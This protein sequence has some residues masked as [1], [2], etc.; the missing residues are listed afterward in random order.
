M[1]GN[2][3]LGLTRDVDKGF[4]V[5]QTERGPIAPFPLAGVFEKDPCFGPTRFS[6]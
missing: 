2:P 4:E 3:L 5:S 6:L 1:S